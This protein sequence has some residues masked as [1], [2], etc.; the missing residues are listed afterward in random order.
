[1]LP[2]RSAIGMNN[3]FAKIATDHFNKACFGAIR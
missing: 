1:V 2:P 3:T